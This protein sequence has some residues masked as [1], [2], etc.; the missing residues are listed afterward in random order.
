MDLQS[1]RMMNSDEIY[2]D[3]C[4]KIEH[5][6]YMPG[7]RISEN[8]LCQQYGATRHM[9]R[10]ALTRLRQ[11]KLVEVYPQRGTF[12]S[13][14]DMDYI[15]DIVFFRESMEQEALRRIIESGA[16]EDVCRRMRICIEQQKHCK[17][18]EEYSEEFYELDNI[19]HK[20][21]YDAVGR[22]KAAEFI[23]EPNIH[24]RRWRNFELRYSERVKALIAEHESLV[25]AIEAKD[26][27]GARK[28]LHNHLET[29]SQYAKTIKDSEKQYVVNQL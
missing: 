28:C 12:V 9:V 22:K 6:V 14:I 25:D 3:L 29:V 10:G 4:D 13:L 20:C 19:F 17:K 8:E 23:A 11:R 1:R 26:I 7:Q 18:G 21:L 15:A 5:L 2:E 24:F 27:E 16:V